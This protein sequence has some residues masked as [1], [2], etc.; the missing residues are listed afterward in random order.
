MA[1]AAPKKLIYRPVAA[2]SPGAGFSTRI[3]NRELEA[4]PALKRQPGSS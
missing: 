3:A 1:V 2:F 4:I